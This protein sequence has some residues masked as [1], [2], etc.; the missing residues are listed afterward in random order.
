VFLC[1][2]IFRKYANPRKFPP[3]YGKKE[4]LDHEKTVKAFLMRF[5]FYSLPE[6]MIPYSFRSSTR[7]FPI[8]MDWA[9]LLSVGHPAV[10][11]PYFRM[12]FIHATG[13]RYGFSF[14]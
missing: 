14:R 2:F 5:S 9:A 7:P 1:Y 8:F 13:R 6:P 10:S 4:S 12:R 11:F 3:K